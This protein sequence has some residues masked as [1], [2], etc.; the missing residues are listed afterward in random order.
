M[1]NASPSPDTGAVPL[2]PPCLS[3][4]RLPVRCALMLWAVLGLLS[5]GLI[6]LPF[7]LG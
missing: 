7:L 6:A 1:T 2:Y 4:T 5:W 3:T